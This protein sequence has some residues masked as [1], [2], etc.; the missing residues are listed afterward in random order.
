MDII[1]HTVAGQQLLGENEAL[2]AELVTS[3]AEQERVREELE[4]SILL[5]NEQL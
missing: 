5:L 3:K 2:R 1:R 4:R